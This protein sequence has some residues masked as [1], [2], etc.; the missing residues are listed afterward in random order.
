[1]SKKTT[2]AEPPTF[3]AALERLE[4]I[5]ARI[6]EDELELD[7]SLRLFEEAI[8]LLRIAETRLGGAE[9]QLRQLLA[10]GEG[11]RLNEFPEER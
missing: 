11:F 6:Q 9:T 3:E 8:G 10:D 7:E 5:V 1:M 2:P 4:E